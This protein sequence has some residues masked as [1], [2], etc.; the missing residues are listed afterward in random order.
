VH[1]HL[2]QH[3]Y[4]EGV[5]GGESSRRWSESERVGEEGLEEATIIWAMFNKIF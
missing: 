2:S 3:I 1:T 5:V 4:D